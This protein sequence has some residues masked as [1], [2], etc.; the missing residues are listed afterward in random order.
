MW[1]FQ[2]PK[3]TIEYNLRVRITYED[4]VTVKAW[5]YHEACKIAEEKVYDSMCDSMIDS[6]T[7]CEEFNPDDYA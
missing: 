5:D 4:Y 6:Y 3:D 2:M 7:E 1:G